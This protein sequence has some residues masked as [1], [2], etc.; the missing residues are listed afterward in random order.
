MTAQEFMRRPGELRR[1]IA[2][3]QERIET[4]RRLAGR[5]APLL[6]D[7]RVQSSPDPG[8]M[9]ALLDD[10]ADE[11]REIRRLEQAVREAEE[12]ILMAV[13]RLPDRNLA[14]LMELRYLDGL[15]WQEVAGLMH[16]SD[17]WIFRL[18]RKAL[19]LLPDFPDDPGGG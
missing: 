11:E 9:Q 13:S 10:A 8:R 14:R 15:D 17:T 12:E 16:Y 3:R 5:S 18:H 7:V 6:R 1:E 19:R 4:L 2:R